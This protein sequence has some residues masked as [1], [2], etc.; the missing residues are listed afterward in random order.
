[1]EPENASK[2]ANETATLTIEIAKDFMSFMQA[3]DRRA[4]RAFYRLLSEEFH[5]GS[6]ASYLAGDEVN[7][8]SAMKHRDFFAAMN[9]KG[10]AL[11]ASMGKV[12]GV[13]LLVIDA[14]F[15]Y[16]LK[17]EWND[18]QRWKITKL[19]GGTGVPAGL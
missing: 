1:M 19:D 6:N 12:R 5:Y 13:F 4:E 16:E 8:I 2:I 17:F 3:V 14:D 7:L 18:L 9:E 11:L 10:R 15:N